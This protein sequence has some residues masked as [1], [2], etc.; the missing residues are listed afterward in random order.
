MDFMKQLLLSSC[1]SK[2]NESHIKS[3]RHSHSL[4]QV[5]SLS[6]KLLVNSEKNKYQL[7]VQGLTNFPKVHWS[8]TSEHQESTGPEQFSTGPEYWNRGNQIC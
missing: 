3:C 8:G 4:G 2:S 1:G 7:H 5:G 6:T